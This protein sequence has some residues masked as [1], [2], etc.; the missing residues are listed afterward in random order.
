MD[1]LYG[2]LAQLKKNIN[3][4]AAVNFFLIFD[5]QNLGSLSGSALKPMLTRN[6]ASLSHWL[7]WQKTKGLK[8]AVFEPQEQMKQT[9]SA[10]RILIN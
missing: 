9:T 8:I 1:V 3:C 6:T 2:G 10:D 5:H 4:I 7:G